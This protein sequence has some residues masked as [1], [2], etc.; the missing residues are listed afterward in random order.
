MKEHRP[1]Y[2]PSLFWMGVALNI[3]RSILWLVIATVLMLL[4]RRTPGL[5]WAGIALLAIVPAVAII[6]QLIYRRAILRSDTP[7][8]ADWQAAMLSP[9]WEENVREMVDR[10]LHDD[11]GEPP[12]EEDGDTPTDGSDGGET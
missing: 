7:E 2:P 10:A 1:H 4:G 9:D 5:G 12:M 11:M 6:R 3:L 8:L